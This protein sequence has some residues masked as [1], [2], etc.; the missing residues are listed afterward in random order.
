MKSPLTLSVHQAGDVEGVLRTAL[1]AHKPVEAKFVV[2]Q[3]PDFHMHCI[4]GAPTSPYVLQHAQ[5]V[6]ILLNE[7]FE[8]QLDVEERGMLPKE[9]SRFV[10]GGGKLLAELDDSRVRAAATFG[11]TTLIEDVGTDTP[12]LSFQRDPILA[13]VKDWAKSVAASIHSS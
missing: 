4:L 13:A 1:Q 5:L 7:L 2:A 6:R 11:S 3:G 12:L 8:L 9:L 10:F